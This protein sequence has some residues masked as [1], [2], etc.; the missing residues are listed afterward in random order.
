MFPPI[1]DIISRL[2]AGVELVKVFKPIA[3]DLGILDK[4][5]A[6]VGKVGSVISTVSEI[7][8]NVVTRIEEGKIVATTREAD[9]IKKLVEEL[10]ADNDALAKQIEDS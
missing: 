8:Q 4:D 7:A 3:E 5:S 10:A 6:I 1:M 2:R 9:T